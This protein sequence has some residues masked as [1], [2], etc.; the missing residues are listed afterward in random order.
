MRIAGIDFSSAPAPRKPIVIASGRLAAG[1]EEGRLRIDAFRTLP[2]LAGFGDWLSADGPWIAGCDFPFGLPR[3]FIDAQGWGRLDWPALLDRVSALTRAELVGRCRAYAAA[4]PAGAKFA[5]RAT[6]RPA[7]SS[8]SMKW[9]NPPVVLMLHAGVPLLRAAGVALPA[10]QPG[11]PTRVALEAYPG[12]IARL[13]IARRS[14]KSDDPRRNDADRRA[15][16]AAIVE[17]LGCGDATGIRVELGDGLQQAC[18]DDFRA[19]RLD[20]VLCAV[21]AAWG[22]LRRDAGWG[23]PADTDPLEGWIVGAGAIGG[24]HEA[25][26]SQN[27]GLSACVRSP[28]PRGPAR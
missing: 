23:L 18:L 6:D 10:L 3:E 19:D 1:R 11:D 13:A 2:T 4:R 22:A 12:L 24:R 27:A 25:T 7:G 17:F 15:A 5:H 9:V 14:Y 16:R 28:R 8:P 20:A 26:A 21:Q